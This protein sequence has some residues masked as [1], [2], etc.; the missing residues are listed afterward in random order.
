MTRQ[1][2]QY[3]AIK[4]QYPE[5][6]LF[7]RMGDFYELFFDDAVSAA[8]AL[9]IA[10]TKRGKHLGEDI[11]MCGVPVHSH[12]TY[13]ARLIRQGFK[14]AV[15]EQQEDPSEAKKRGAKSVV[16]RDVVRVITAGTLTEDTL[17]ETRR[18][19][20]LAA[21]AEDRGALGLAWIDIST[22]DFKTQPVDPGGL[23]AA[24]ARLEPGEFL[25]P[26][27]LLQ[28]PA[29]FETLGE[30]RERLTPLPSSRFDRINGRKRI[31][32]LYEVD[33]IDAF[34][35]FSGG[36]VAAAGALVDYVKLTQKGR[37]PRLSRVERLARGAVMEI[38]S[39]TRRN[40]ELSQTLSG[41]R[42]G[43]LLSTIDRT[44]S[45]PGARLLASWLSSPL[46]DVEEINLRLDMVQFFVEA[47]RVR[48]DLRAAL[49]RCSDLQR[50][51]SRLSLGRGGPRDLAAVR[52]GLT[53]ASEV[54]AVLRPGGLPGFPRGVEACVHDLG[55]HDAVVDR[56]NRALAPS[57]PVHAR[58]GGFIA[59]GYVARLDELRQLRD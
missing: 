8:A 41:E 13:L 16:R 26:D 12:E 11:P 9:D 40:L 23:G 42:K 58:D 43:S 59:S 18:H 28:R 39:S 19:N 56:L 54:R 25:I 7:Y 36:E 14:V 24:L 5:C 53:L 35:A 34:G 27:G 10:L 45:A 22:G 57:Q 1:L 2:R 47:E 44:V 30:W 20:Y 52:D 51:L 49:K 32:S 4:R 33:T 6:L 15:C 46:T 48:E 21:C 3:L 37:I 17:L 31:E 50:A 29:L 38:D 55:N